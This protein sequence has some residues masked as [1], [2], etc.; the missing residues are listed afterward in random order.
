[1]PAPIGLYLN[2]EWKIGA[3]Q[4]LYSAAGTWFHRLERFPGALC[5]QDG[6]I[7]FNN[8]TEY[9]NCEYVKV[10]KQ[11]NVPGGIKELVGYV[12]RRQ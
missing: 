8:E 12:R 2:K 11:T 3:A 1:M 10:G 7:I 9:L 5:D 4:A 6:Y